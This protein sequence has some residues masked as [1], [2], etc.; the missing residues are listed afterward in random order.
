MKKVIAIAKYDSFTKISSSFLLNCIEY[1]YKATLVLIKDSYKLSKRQ[2]NEIY[3]TNIEII[4]IINFKD[5]DYLKYDVVYLGLTGGPIKRFSQFFYKKYKDI[6]N[7]PIIICGYPG[8]I[9]TSRFIGYSNRAFCDIILL[10]SIYD[11]E[12]YK[13]FSLW[14]NLNYSNAFVY[15]YSFEK[16]IKK[17]CNKKYIVFAEQSVI[18]KTFRDRMYLVGRLLDYADAN[19]DENIIIKPRIKIGE[20]T[21]FTCKYPFEKLIILWSLRRNIPQNINFSYE[22]IEKLLNKCSLLITVS[23]TV[24]IQSVY[25]GI[26]TAIIGDFGINEEMGIDFYMNS[27]C[28]TL[29]DDL[30]QNKFICNIN[31]EWFDKNIV[32]CDTKKELFFKFLEKKIVE[33]NK[34]DKNI[35]NFNKSICKKYNEFLFKIKIRERIILI[36]F[37]IYYLY[38]RYL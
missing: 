8:V 36:F 19:P 3:L 16:I 18:P 2:L 27:G 34:L 23:S 38:R 10:N 6:N 29:F 25:S 22:K 30:I 11:F 31:K 13:K 5:I 33:S 24:A 28:V 1:G 7:R 26:P 17:Q 37:Y 9:L 20:K 15:G 14:Y 12:K 32:H 21:I 35:D 4:S